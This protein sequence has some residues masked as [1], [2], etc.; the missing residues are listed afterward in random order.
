MLHRYV[1]GAEPLVG[2]AVAVPLLLEQAAGVED[3]AGGEPAP[4]FT[5]AVAETVIG[6][7][8]ELFTTVAV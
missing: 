2:V 1:K 6:P 4:T 8:Q 5:V 3:I 7:L